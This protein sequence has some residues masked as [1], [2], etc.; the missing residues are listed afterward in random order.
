MA[1]AQLK[2]SFIS[3]GEVD[4]SVH[5]STLTLK[6]S[7][8]TTGMRYFIVSN[9]HNRLV[10]YGHYA[11]HH[12]ADDKELAMRLS[13]IFAKDELLQLKFGEV[14]V[15]ID[16]PYTLLPPALTNL[17]KPIQELQFCKAT[18]LYIAFEI[19]FSIKEPLIEAFPKAV[20]S[21]LN[22]S[23]LEQ[24]PTY[25]IDNTDKL[26]VSIQQDYFDVI[27]FK[28]STSL[29]MM[30]RY[31]YRTETD[32]IYFLLLCCEGLNINR[33]KTELV[34]INEVKKPS[35]IY[36][37]CFRYFL[38]I[39]FI[40]APKHTSFSKQLEELP[41]HHHFSLYTLTA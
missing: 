20:F 13:K 9:T 2:N 22:T 19:P 31:Q 11:L 3:L 17:K 38:N 18:D 21:H 26:F 7:V 25:L 12:V 37:I 10:F 1:S 16:T 6:L 8:N 14:V 39:E 40:N 27:R 36:D 35:K 34:L 29:L 5:P 32:F 15:G 23:L 4:S 28:G 41:P 30:N 24:L 33:E